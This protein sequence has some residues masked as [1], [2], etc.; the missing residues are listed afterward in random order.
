MVE[1]GFKSEGDDQDASTQ[2]NAAT[3]SNNNQSPQRKKKRL[4]ITEDEAACSA[5]HRM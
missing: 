4:E 2:S 5:D 3:Q 1:I